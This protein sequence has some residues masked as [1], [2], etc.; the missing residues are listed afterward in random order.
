MRS[1]FKLLLFGA[2]LLPGVFFGDS[3]TAK[4]GLVDLNNGAVLDITTGLVWQKSR[5]PL[6][7]DWNSAVEYCNN[8]DLAGHA[9]W[10]LPSVKEIETLYDDRQISPIIDVGFFPDAVTGRYWTGTSKFLQPGSVEAWV[11]IMNYGS[12]ELKE[13]SIAN[14]IAKCVT[15]N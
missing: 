13:K 5:N 4:V 9:N 6:S 2:L 8:L 11:V 12:T 15:D 1:Q 7:V 14:Y 10:R 3:V